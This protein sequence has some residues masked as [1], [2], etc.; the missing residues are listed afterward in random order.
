MS[1]RNINVKEVAR[2][3]EELF[4]EANTVLR[5]DVVSALKRLAEEEKNPKAK[6]MLEIL[7]ENSKIAEKKSMPLCQDTGLAVV[8]LNI[9]RDVVFTE[10]YINEAVDKGVLNAYEKG[11]LRKSIVKDPVLRGNTGTN[12]PAF[13]HIEIVPGNKVEIIVLPKGFGSENKSG[14]A[15][16]NPTAGEDAIV[17]FCVEVVRKAGPDACPPYVLGVGIGGTAEVCGLLA[18]KALTRPIDSRNPQEHIA[19]LEDE[20]EKKVKELEIGVMGLGGISTVMGVNIEIAPTHIAGL[21]V[22]VNLSCH[23]LRSART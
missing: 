20:I 3:V 14:L 22:A 8:F 23:A 6:K 10:G 17:D 4:I 15:M 21:P 12:T 2:A 9:G 16:L 13:M 11:F 7:V 1:T 18:K 5:Q 19:R